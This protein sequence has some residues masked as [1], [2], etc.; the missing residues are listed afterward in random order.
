MRQRDY[1]FLF[2][3][4]LVGWLIGIL[5]KGLVV[6]LNPLALIFMRLLE[7]IMVPLVI[8]SLSAGIINLGRLVDVRRLVRGALV[9]FFLSTGCSVLLGGV[10]VVVTHPG[11]KVI[12]AYYQSTEV[13]P[14]SLDLT[15][16]IINQLIPSNF[17][18]LLIQGNM[19]AIIFVAV[20][21]GVIVNQLEDKVV[22]FGQVIDS[23]N[24]LFLKISQWIIKVIP[25]GVMTLTAVAVSQS[26]MQ[27]VKYVFVYFLTV[28]V[29]LLIYVGCIIPLILLVFG[30]F[31]PIYF[32]KQMT[33]A[34]VTAFS[35]S[36]SIITIPVTLN[37]LEN[38]MNIPKKITGIV[39]ALGATLNM[40]GTA[41]FKIIAAV[42]ISQV[43]GI[44]LSLMNYI[45]LIVTVIFMS[46]GT[47]GIPGAGIVTLSIA[48]KSVGLPLEG[49]GL[50]LAVDRL[51]DMSR[52]VVN[53]LSDATCAIILNEEIV[54]NEL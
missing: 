44:E 49:I 16:S 36:S 26:E 8:T 37:C 34:I 51:L 32:F 21:I 18:K 46:F 52:T 13:T 2:G 33:P 47:A 14:F 50:I 27:V 35:T 43:Y 1:A 39:T 20:T 6:Y 11:Q 25:I 3:A 31:S 22:Y 41:L 40:D 48:L 29:G 12:K 19:I 45:V 4:V 38:K 17:F 9:Y 28:L 15:M 7:M 5:F 23:L 10:L 53:M 30:N 24:E 54:Q 42:F